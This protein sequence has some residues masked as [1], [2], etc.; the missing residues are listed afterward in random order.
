MVYYSPYFMT[1][2]CYFSHSCCCLSLRDVRWNRP[3]SHSLLFPS[4]LFT[5]KVRFAV[6]DRYSYEKIRTASLGNTARCAHLSTS[7]HIKP[8][9][10]GSGLMWR[11]EPISPFQWCRMHIF[12]ISICIDIYCPPSLS[13]LYSYL[14]VIIQI[15]VCSGAHPTK[16]LIIKIILSF[17]YLH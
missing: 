12:L 2:L 1:F 5:A 17:S 6:S 15:S 10:K 8:S 9:P 11:L 4:P 16:H 7:H 14:L 13:S 3:I